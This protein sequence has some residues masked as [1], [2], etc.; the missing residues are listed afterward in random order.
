MHAPRSTERPTRRDAVRLFTATSAAVALGGPAALFN[1]LEAASLPAGA[2]Y[3][4]CVV[5]PRQ[6]EGPY[7]VDERLH[8]ADI[9]QDPT[10]GVVKA[11]LPLTLAVNL[12]KIE[13]GQCAPLADAMVDVWQCDAQG[14][15]AGVLDQGRRFDTRGQKFLRGY[16]V[17]GTDGR[18]EFTTIYPGWYPGRTV[19]I[20]F[21]VRT[22][23]GG[24]RAGEFTSQW[25]F[26]DAITDQVLATG[27]YAA[28]GARSTRNDRDGIYRRG[29]REL[30]LTLTPAATGYAAAFD[31]G[32]QL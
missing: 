5:V 19:H 25:Y 12:T 16:Q 10:N 15:Y 13:N 24:G 4:P 17:T 32:L 23:T 30:M 31:L 29:G 6:T 11:G 26:D 8:R 18:V 27:P 1:R 21:K 20:H 22:N 7:F 9:R 14:Q 2:A 3:P 28:K